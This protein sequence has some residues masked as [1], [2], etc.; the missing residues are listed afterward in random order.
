MQ[1]IF[2]ARD[3]DNEEVISAL[4]SAAELYQ[5]GAMSDAIAWLRHASAAAYRHGH[6]ARADQL[7]RD[8]DH[9][10]RQTPGGGEAEATQAD[11][12]LPHFPVTDS[13]MPPKQRAP[14]ATDAHA[15]ILDPWAERTEVGPAHAT[16]DDLFTSAKVMTKTG[17]RGTLPTIPFEEAPPKPAAPTPPSRPGRGR[18]PPLPPRARS[19]QTGEHAVAEMTQPASNVAPASEP[20]SPPPPQVV[21]SAPP[22]A[23]SR[24]TRPPVHDS[25]ELDLSEIEALADLPDDSREAFG[26]AATVKHL[27]TGEDLRDFALALVV[28]GE[29]DVEMTTVDAPAVRFGEGCAIR[30]RGTTEHQVPIRL[31]CASSDAI[32]AVWDAA[33]VDEAFATC[34]WVEDELRQSADKV[35]AWVGITVGPLGERLDPGLR[36]QITSRLSVRSLD[37]GEVIVKRGE[38]IPG[39]IVV[40]VG[41]LEI[42]SAT[43]QAEQVIG[44]GH[45]V[46]PSEV[47][48]AGKA[49]AD[50]RAGAGG[51]LVLFG[52]R[53]IA[54]E[55]MVTCPPLLEVFAGM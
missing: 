20:S 39:L 44:P 50:V 26:Q 12:R 15:G 52:A 31:V 24:A 55:L 27:L 38:A 48:G 36:G 54:Q 25:G 30:C 53:G 5:R 16:E 8:A 2:Q 40:G 3:Q 18:P 4:R 35:L 14:S 33:H 6:G 1:G 41:E 7:A 37:E 43:G 45:F 34:P 23:E 17:P 21:P 51:T 13:M 29:V 47:L 28:A 49:P 22:R 46:F 32:V 42:V 10:A 9:L 11:L 19:G